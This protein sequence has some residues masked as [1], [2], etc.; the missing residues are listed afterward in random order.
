M[1]MPRNEWSDEE[2]LA[3][4]TAYM[5][6]L[7]LEEQGKAYVKAGFHRGLIAGQLS[8][9]SEGSIEFRMRNISAVL[10]ERGLPWIQGYKP[11]RNVGLRVRERLEYLLDNYDREDEARISNA[12]VDSQQV[13]VAALDEDELTNAA[14]KENF[15]PTDIVD[16]RD[17]VLVAITRRRGQPAF[18]KAL[19]TA[20]GGRCA[21]TGYA[22]SAVLEAAHIYPYMGPETNHVTNG[23][24]MRADLHTLFDMGLLSIDMETLPSGASSWTVH[25]DPS[26]RGGNYEDLHGVS[27]RL[28]ESAAHHPSA[29]ALRTRLKRAGNSESPTE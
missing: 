5:E 7:L 26:L 25:I 3:A 1:V 23:I 17:R 11:A 4:L 10:E 14:K 15:D 21:I 6:M 28:P 24:L 19:M 9:R 22:V 2:L 16:A 12:S 18:R 8:S 29:S 13:A 20:Y 27:L